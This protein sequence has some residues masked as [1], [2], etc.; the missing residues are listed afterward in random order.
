MT[1]YEILKNGFDSKIAKAIL[2]S[3]I[4]IERN[5]ALRKWK[6]SELDAGHFV[7]AVRRAIEKELVGNYQPFN[8][9]LPPFNDNALKVYEQYSGDESYRLIIPRVLVIVDF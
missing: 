3:Y 1:P 8:K 6:P 2:E 5:Y 9:S 4:E 7:E